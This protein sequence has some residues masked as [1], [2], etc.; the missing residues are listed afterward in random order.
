MLSF[1][2]KGKAMGSYINWPPL[3]KM[4]TSPDQFIRVYTAPR[5]T[6]MHGLYIH[7][8]EYM[9]Y[10]IRY[11]MSVDFLL[12]IQVLTTINFISYNKTFS[13]ADVECVCI[14]YIHM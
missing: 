2:F 12:N 11:S 7:H 10:T 4:N 14:I 13:G 8:A 1:H 5:L 9:P 3:T 6:V